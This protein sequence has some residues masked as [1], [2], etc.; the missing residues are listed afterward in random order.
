MWVAEHLALWFAFLFVPKILREN[1]FCE[2]KPSCVGY[3]VRGLEADV[4]WGVIAVAKYFGNR[5]YC[6]VIAVV[7]L[8]MAMVMG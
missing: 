1:I 7:S 3:L 2:R 6:V 5:R 4:K 8:V